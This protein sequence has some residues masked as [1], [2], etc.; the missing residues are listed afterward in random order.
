MNTLFIKKDVI[1][2]VI[3]HAYNAKPFEGCGLLVG[4]SNHI[5]TFLPL[6]NESNNHY[7]YKVSYEQLNRLL[8]QINFTNQELIAIYHSHPLQRAVPSS[9]DLLNHPD[10]SIK[11]IIVSLKQGHPVVKC[12]SINNR[13]YLECKLIVV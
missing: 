12:Y 1:D 6:V 3:L 8:Q 7:Q 5:H 13:D 11:M 2:E 10:D 9:L 4:N